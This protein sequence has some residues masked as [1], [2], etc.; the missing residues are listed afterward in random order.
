MRNLDNEICNLL[1][2]HNVEGLKLLFSVYYRPLVL[3][4]DTYLNNIGHAEDVVQEFFVKLWEKKFGD[5]LSALTLKSYLF[6]AVKNQALNVLEKFDPLK[7]TCDVALVNHFQVEYD[8]LTEELLSRVKAEIKKLSPRSQEVVNGVYLEGLHYK[9]VAQKL[10]ISVSTV[11]TLLV[12]ALKQL[13]T[14]CEHINEILT[15]ILYKKITI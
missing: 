4:A 7:E 6:T 9:E 2:Q 3:W 14:S 5:R 13:R 10:G 11:K 8:D 1:K 12:N 15:F